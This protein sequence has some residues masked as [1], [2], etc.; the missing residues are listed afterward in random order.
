MLTSP[1]CSLGQAYIFWDR[2]LLELVQK[3]EVEGKDVLVM[4]RL[5]PLLL[6][7]WLAAAPLDQPLA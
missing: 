1:V 3:A 2:D 5:G 6:R 4:G 7:V